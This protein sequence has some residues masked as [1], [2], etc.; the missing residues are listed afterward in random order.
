MGDLADDA[1]VAYFGGELFLV[2]M[3]AGGQGDAKDDQP[4][5][6]TE[7]LFSSSV[8]VHPKII[9]RPATDCQAGVFSAWSSRRCNPWAALPAPLPR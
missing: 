7:D 3:K 2:K 1:V 4:G 6:E 9:R 8:V 5:E